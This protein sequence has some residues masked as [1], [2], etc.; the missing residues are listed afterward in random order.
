MKSKPNPEISLSTLQCQGTLPLMLSHC[1]AWNTPDVAVT[2]CKCWAG[3]L[4]TIILRCGALG[5]SADPGEQ[6][7]PQDCET[8]PCSG[9]LWSSHTQDINILSN[10]Q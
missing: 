6:L 2:Q 1:W 8:G 5:P 3:L 4:D 7:Q 9:R 10:S